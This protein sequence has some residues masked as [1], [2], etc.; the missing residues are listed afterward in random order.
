MS[1]IESFLFN[2]IYGLALLILPG[3]AIA[4]IVHKLSRGSL[5]PFYIAA[6]TS[7]LVF[8]IAP[9]APR[10]LF[11]RRVLEQAASIPGVRLVVR[12]G[13]ILSSR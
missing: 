6:G 13:V 1:W 10:F 3:F 11:E 7:V 9:S 8:L 12:D 5:L 2:S 4:W